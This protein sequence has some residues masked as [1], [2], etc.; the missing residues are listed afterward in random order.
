MDTIRP[1]GAASFDWSLEVV[2]ALQLR[3]D[4]LAATA[5][6]QGEIGGVSRPIHLP[7]TI[8]AAGSGGSPGR[9]EVVLE[10]GAELTEVFSTLVPIQPD[11]TPGPPFSDGVA[12]G[13]PFYPAGVPVRIP[14]DLDAA[15]P[16]LYLLEIAATLPGGGGATTRIWLECPAADHGLGPEAL[17]GHE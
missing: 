13:R 9:Y 14:V 11:G 7:V 5:W 16:G 15:G 4:D 3:S 6:W 2:R 12:L 8:G 17:D 10:P 1:P